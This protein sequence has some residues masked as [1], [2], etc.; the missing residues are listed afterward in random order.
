MA[1]KTERQTYEKT[2]Y[3]WGDLRYLR[4]GD[5]YGCVIHPACMA[6]IERAA[7]LDITTTFKDEQGMNWL[8]TV[9]DGIVR[10]RFGTYH[11]EI[12]LAELRA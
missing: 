8:V 5:S 10:L 7:A 1:R 11:F 2:S 9:V 3:S 12:T 6:E 4:R